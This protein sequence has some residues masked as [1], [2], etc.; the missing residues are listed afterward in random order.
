MIL[1][2]LAR[3]GFTDNTKEFEVATEDNM[4]QLYIL[5]YVVLN[6]GISYLRNLV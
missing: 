5:T 4:K 2:K 3:P 1:Y 6:K